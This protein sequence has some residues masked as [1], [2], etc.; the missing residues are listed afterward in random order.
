LWRLQG[1]ALGE[2]VSNKFGGVNVCIYCMLK[3]LG[4]KCQRGH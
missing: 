4:S 3:L 2:Q 1:S